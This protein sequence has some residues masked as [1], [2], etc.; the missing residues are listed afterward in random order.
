MHLHHSHNLVCTY[1]MYKSSLS[2][3]LLEFVNNNS[4]ILSLLSGRERECCYFSN[5]F[6]TLFS[7]TILSI[8][9]VTYQKSFFIAMSQSASSA[10]TTG[11]NFAIHAQENRV[12]LTHHN[13][14]NIKYPIRTKKQTN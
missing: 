8:L 6:N 10:V 9:L 4:E 5:F 7:C 13:L 3:P 14:N 1:N 11:E 2:S 12:K